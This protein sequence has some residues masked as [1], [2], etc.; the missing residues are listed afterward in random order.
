M[1]ERSLFSARHCFVENLH[2]SGKMSDA[3]FSVLCEWF[4]FL[5]SGNLSSVDVGVDLIIYLRTKP[6]VAYERKKSRARKEEEVC[7]NVINQGYFGGC[8]CLANY[9]YL[10]WEYPSIPNLFHRLYHWSTLK[11]CIVYMKSGYLIM[12]SFQHLY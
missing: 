10:M 7:F 6:E 4:D 5:A 3:E 9:E 12:T 8:Y 2:D 11:N 1:M